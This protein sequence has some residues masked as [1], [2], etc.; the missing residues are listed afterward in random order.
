MLGSE[1]VLVSLVPATVLFQLDED[2]VVEVFVPGVSVRLVLG[3][4]GQFCVDSG[5]GVMLICVV[6]LFRFSS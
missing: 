2:V 3:C 6:R 1:I 4:R 5:L